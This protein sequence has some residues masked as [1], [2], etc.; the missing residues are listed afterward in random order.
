MADKILHAIDT[1]LLIVRGRENVASPGE[2]K[3]ES[4]IVPLD[5][6]EVAERALFHAVGISG[7]LGIPIHPVSVIPSTESHAHEEDQLRQQGERLVADGAHSVEPRV[8]PTATRPM[9]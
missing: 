6:S 2:A 5:G 9:A 4:V 3:L 7:A 1:P 8:S